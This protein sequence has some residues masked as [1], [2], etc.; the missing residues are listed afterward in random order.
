MASVTFPPAVG[1]DGSTVS[2]D[3]NPTTG[4]GNGGHR[5]RFVPTL[6]QMVAV[7]QNTVTQ[8]TNAAASASDAAASAATAL[9]SPG[10]S[11][12]ST[13]SLVVGTGSKSLTLAQTGKAF[14]VGQFVQIV[15]TATPTNWMVGPITAFNSG[16]GAMTVNVGSFGGSGTIAAWT[17]TPSS[18][19]E[20]PSQ[21]G[22]AGRVLKTDGSVVSW[23]DASL[24][25]IRS[26]RTSNTQIVA[27]DTTTLID[28][29]SGTFTQTFAAC[30][31]LGNGWWC[32]IRNSGTG[33]ITL[34]PNASE[35][36]DGLTTFVMYPNEVR[37]LQ[38]DGTALRSIVLEPFYKQFTAS[39]TF[40]VPPGYAGF[41]SHII[42]AG[43]GGAGGSTTQV[44]S[45][46]GGG[47]FRPVQITS[48]TAGTSITV[49]VGAGGIGT[50]GGDG[51]AGGDSTF[52]GFTAYGGG[53]GGI[54]WPALVGGGGGGW[55]SA[56]Q[57]TFQGGNGGSPRALTGGGD[58]LGTAASGVDNVGG[59]G[60][61]STTSAAAG[62][63]EFGG[64]AGS[65]TNSGGNGGSS[66]YGAGGGAAAPGDG[67]RSGAYTTGG[68]GAA[69][70]GNGANADLANGKMCGDGGGCSAAPNGSQGGTGG[71][72]GGGGGAGRA[73][74][75]GTTGG[76]WGA[77]GEVRIWGL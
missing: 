31:T 43:G 65:S 10:T 8:A 71:I 40:I 75:T 76:G 48:P 64:G 68:G 74:T 77:R 61:A 38:C 22:N 21:G 60:A 66:V 26:A 42:G 17:I 33:D 24:P 35:T 45:G 47:A 28:I 63:A 20:L 32:F 46:G 27:A 3:S 19:N 73:A 51:F 53:G 52:A 57:S 36:I 34:D 6:V 44:G 23:A 59:G 15:S 14:A 58:R 39:G 16:T 67:G 7:A 72:P 55:I 62:N 4:L 11:A 70:G 54:G 41:F 9:N 30:S 1:G 5:T 50:N 18:P 69:N 49:T 37:L 2:D 25:V 56:G 12:T 29:T 13:T